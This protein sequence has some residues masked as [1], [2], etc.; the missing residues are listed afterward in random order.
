[1]NIDKI[2]KMVRCLKE[3]G[4][5]TMNTASNAGIAGFSGNAA[6]EGPTAGYDM[7][8]DGRCKMMRRLP[9]AYRKLLSKGKR[10]KR[11]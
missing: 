2:I 1:M 7:P 11:D 5:P 4:S 10:R 3:E 9:P 6:P 8:L